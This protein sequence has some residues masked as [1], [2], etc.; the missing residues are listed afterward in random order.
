ML[1][2]LIAV[3]AVAA[4]VVPAMGYTITNPSNTFNIQLNIGEFVQI[5][6]Q[7]T[8]MVFDGATD[9]WSPQL[10]NV[11]YGGCP[12]NYGHYPTDVF[13]GDNYPDGMGMYYE[14]G[15]GATIYLKSN[16]LLSMQVT[17]S[18]DLLGAAS[19]HTIPT[20]FT[21]CLAPFQINGVAL[22][23]T[24]PG[25]NGHYLYDAGS[26]A[27]GHGNN[28]TGPSGYD[29]Y[30]NQ[31]PFACAGSS[32]WTLGPMAPYV[33]GSIKF[34]ARCYRLGMSDPADTYTTTLGILFTAP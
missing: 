9:W 5:L 23:G 4:L 16:T 21:T 10:A 2:T 11:G 30:P 29:N 22:N 19:A 31:E 28:G 14:S 7:D 24:V 33:E 12:D 20:W 17:T 6:W 34:L 18:G 26:G 27:F 32:T 8:D 13:A 3:M 1:R 25:S 15:D